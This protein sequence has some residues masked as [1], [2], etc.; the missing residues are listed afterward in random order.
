MNPI[1]AFVVVMLVWTVSDLVAK[2]TRSLLSSLFV[3]SIIFLVGFL[4]ED[5]LR[6][7]HADHLILGG[8]KNLRA[9]GGTVEESADGLRITGFLTNTAPGG[10]G[11]QLADLEL[12]HRRHART[13]CANTSAPRSVNR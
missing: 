3:A 2:K 4:T 9:I 7:V 10:P 12:R 1:L 8:E 11:R 13:S 6:Q 5:N